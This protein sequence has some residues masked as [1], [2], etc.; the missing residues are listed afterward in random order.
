[1]IVCT[2]AAHFFEVASLHEGCM[3]GCN[4]GITVVD[5]GNTGV[6]ARMVTVVSNCT[7]HTTDANMGGMQVAY[8]LRQAAYDC[9]QPSNDRK[10]V[11]FDGNTIVCSLLQ[12]AFS[13][14][15]ILV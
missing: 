9:K 3:K 4:A 11:A 10:Q 1:M 15:C 13:L 7:I 6:N 12:A 5:A 8:D 14:Q 2:F